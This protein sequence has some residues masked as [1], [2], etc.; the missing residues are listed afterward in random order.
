MYVCMFVC[1]YVCMYVC[2]YK[3]MCVHIQYTITLNVQIHTHI[4]CLAIDKNIIY[5]KKLGPSMH[6][7][8]YHKVVSDSH[9]CLIW[10]NRLYSKYWC[11]YISYIYDMNT[12]IYMIYDITYYTMNIQIY[13]YVSILYRCICIY[14]YKYIDMYICKYTISCYIYIYSIY[15]L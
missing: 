11:H 10:C 15:I 3:S 9:S 5:P 2:V 1:M 7:S 14:M 12:Y 8:T 4:N 6:K 13:V